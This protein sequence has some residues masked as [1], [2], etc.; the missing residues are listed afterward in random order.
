MNLELI[1][2]DT[3]SQELQKKLQ[4]LKE[5]LTQ[6]KK[7][8]NDFPEGHLRVAQKGIKRPQ[9]YHYTS[10]N[11]LTGKYL[12]KNQTNFAKTLAQKDY[13]KNIIQILQEEIDALE[14]YLMK[15]EGGKSISNYYTTLCT[16]RRSLITPVTLTDEQYVARWQE[17]T[18]KGR[19]YTQDT[20]DYYTS[21]GEHVR[22]KSE[23]I[24]AD[25]LARHDIPYRY[26]FPLQLLRSSGD[27]ATLYPDFLCLNIRTRAEF[28]WEHFGLMDD[29]DY[30]DNAAGKLRLYTE[31]GI[32]PGRNLII[33]METKNDPIST[34]CIDKII[35][36]YLEN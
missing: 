14:K 13:N 36:E 4:K 28:Y 9:Y 8:E 23:V 2:P 11:N 19:P 16:P 30:S 29:S 18:W 32:L 3:L 10:P 35:N 33:T 21:R 24:I 6:L 31:N 22:S 15:T 12:R 5:A 27:T 1:P 7:T 25:A 17:I 34:R 20:P 26:E